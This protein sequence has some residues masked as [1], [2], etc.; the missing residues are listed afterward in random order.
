MIESRII[1]TI[2]KVYGAWAGSRQANTD[3]AGEFG[4][5]ARHERGHLLVP[6]LNEVE[7]VAS[8]VER[9]YNSGNTVARKPENSTDIPF[10]KALQE[11]IADGFAHVIISKREEA[12]R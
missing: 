8:A 6:H 2:Q 11:E 3:L 7:Q 12:V 1:E 9:R 10:R 5:G 4:M